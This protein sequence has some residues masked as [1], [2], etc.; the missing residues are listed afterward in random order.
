MV[1]NSAN[2]LLRLHFTNIVPDLVEIVEK[3]HP[4]PIFCSDFTKHRQTVT[5]NQSVTFVGLCCTT[6]SQDV[7]QL[8]E[9]F[10][11]QPKRSS[12]TT[13]LLEVT[14]LEK[15]PQDWYESM[16]LSFVNMERRVCFHYFC[17]CLVCSIAGYRTGIKYSTQ[18]LFCFQQ[19]VTPNARKRPR[20]CFCS[21]LKAVCHCLQSLCSMGHVNIGP[22]CHFSRIWTKM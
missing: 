13:K 14:G 18:Q 19:K 16:R 20:L 6:Q 9:L 3:W 7:L 15:H 21:V 12:T 11:F 1:T 17:Q 22:G 4:G 5:S 8:C 2:G 10:C